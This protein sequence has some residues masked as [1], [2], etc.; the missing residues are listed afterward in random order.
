MDQPKLGL[1]L[2]GT[3][4]LLA[5]VIE[6]VYG[7]F[8]WWVY[9][10]SKA[11]L[12]VIVLF[13]LANLSMLSSAVPGPEELLAGHPTVIVT[14]IAAQIVITLTL[15]NILSRRSALTNASVPEQ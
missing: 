7:A 9:N 10:G 2:Y 13:N 1:G 12:A 4:P 5:F 11:L 15:V 8:C 14:V 6:I 3:A